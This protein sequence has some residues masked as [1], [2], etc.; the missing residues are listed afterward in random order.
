MKH[1][2]ST[3]TLSNTALFLLLVQVFFLGYL[4][5]GLTQPLTTIFLDSSDF[6]QETPIFFEESEEG[7]FVT[8]SPFSLPSGAYTVFV[9]YESRKYENENI[10]DHGGI[11]TYSSKANPSAVTGETILLTDGYQEIQE[12]L[13]VKKFSFLEDFVF[14]IH[15][16][17]T[18]TLEVN[19]IELRESFIFRVVTLI[20]YLILFFLVDFFYYLVV[21]RKKVIER[22]YF[23]LFLL[24]FFVNLP[25]FVDF[26]FYGHDFNFHLTRIVSVANELNYGAFPVRMMSD[27][28][29]NY[30]YPNSLFYCDFFLYFPAIL[31]NA[32]VPLYLCY[33][34]YIITINLLTMIFSYHCFQRLIKKESVA[35]LCTM[36]YLFSSYRMIC[37]YTRAA[38]GEYTAMAFLPL[39]LTGVLEIYTKEKPKFESWI[40]LT[41]GMSGLFL[42]H[43]LTFQLT[44][45]VLFLFALGNGKNT[46]QRL[47][48]LSLATITTIGV[49]L[50]FLVPFLESMTMNIAVTSGNNSKI[51]NTGLYLIQLFGVFTT[52]TGGNTMFLQNEMP[53]SL[54]FPLSFSFLSFTGY[55]LFFYLKKDQ[56]NQN[57]VKI[58]KPLLFFSWLTLCFS[59][60]IFPWDFMENIF[61][62]KIASFFATIQFTW[63]WL[64]LS[65]LLVTISCLYLFDIFSKEYK[66]HFPSILLL[67]T[68]FTILTTGFY[69][70]NYMNESSIKT[71]N[72]LPRMDMMGVMGGEYLL[73]GTEI[74]HL[75]EAKVVSQATLISAE[76]E[77]NKRYFTVKNDNDTMEP[78]TLPVLAYDHY[79]LYDLNT[80][81]ILT[82]QT[83]E[84]NQITIEIPRNYEGTLCLEYQGP[85]LWR[86]AEIFSLGTIL[87]LVWKKRKLSLPYELK[88]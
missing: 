1:F 22:K 29:N 19:T 75:M 73:E 63:R 37:V 9:S 11:I 72:T 38:M 48:P 15:Y 25:L 67:L 74:N 51:Q 57:Y 26:L 68:S 30:G 18:G 82:I 79:Q 2:Y 41:M 58:I 27:M 62:S 56:V 24:G 36:L 64:S 84:N 7:T 55:F 78:M 52:S 31:Y 5:F 85:V 40:Y 88:K 23:I 21:V 59:L 32:M 6:L 28:L 13:W 71:A 17:G 86:I 44:V 35:L 76:K 16:E 46:I 87:L 81:E 80:K 77:G 50:W 3:L 8:S 20:K 43:L 12:R 45:L 47:I 39:V 53:L 49:V 4:F 42:S 60:K 66:K 83:G 69:L 34:I 70:L 33:Q 61:G 65:T 54:G 10:Q 14:H